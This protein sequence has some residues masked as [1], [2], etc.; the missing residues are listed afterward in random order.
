MGELVRRMTQRVLWL[1]VYRLFARGFRAP[2]R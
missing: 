2:A 1:A